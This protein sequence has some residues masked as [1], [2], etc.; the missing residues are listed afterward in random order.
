MYWEVVGNRFDV[1]PPPSSA[2]GQTG[3][4]K[5]QIL[6][7][8]PLSPLLLLLKPLNILEDGRKPYTGNLESLSY[9]P[10]ALPCGSNWGHKINDFV[11]FGYIS[12]ITACMQ[13]LSHCLFVLMVYCLNEYDVF[14]S[15]ASGISPYFFKYLQIYFLFIEH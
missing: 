8:L 9:L 7:F 15:L 10:L 13:C 11:F 4:I 12:F 2:A 14:L 6:Y 1:P 5:V 3:I